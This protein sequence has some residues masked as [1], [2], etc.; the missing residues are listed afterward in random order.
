MSITKDACLL[1]PAWMPY[2]ISTAANG[3]T[4]VFLKVSQSQIVESVFLDR[5]IKFDAEPKIHE[6]FVSPESVGSI[7]KE[8]VE[9]PFGLIVHTGFC[10]STLIAGLLNQ[11][12]ERLVLREPNILTNFLA[13]SQASQLG[14]GFTDKLFS[15]IVNLLSRRWAPT[16]QIII[17]PS[18]LATSLAAAMAARARRTIAIYSDEQKFLQ[19]VLARGEAGRIFLRQLF[20]AQTE[21]GDL[22][23]LPKNELLK[24]S[25]LQAGVLAWR[26]QLSAL[27]RLFSDVS[28]PN[29]KS[30]L[31]EQF[32]NDP[33]SGLR[34]IQQHLRE[35]EDESP[36][37]EASA[38]AAMQLDSKTAQ[39]IADKTALSAD[40]LQAIIDAATWADKARVTPDVSAGLPCSVLV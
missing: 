3:A 9:S 11:P 40:T 20:M 5:R 32:K 38:R 12:R 24:L 30:V 4:L 37:D 15:L 23:S 39:P 13:F 26:S 25:D 7:L 28:N 34:R 33:I 29:I 18:N 6:L 14:S 22:A 2:S 19:S 1:D 8:T 10:G 21:D 17:K 36:V 16:E 35:A 27:R 31:F